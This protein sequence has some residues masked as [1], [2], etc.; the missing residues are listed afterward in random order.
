MY[1]QTEKGNEM[2][3][4]KIMLKDANGNAIAEIIVAGDEAT[5]EKF[6]EMFHPGFKA[7]FNVKLFAGS[8]A[9]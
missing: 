8:P 9:D 1:R 5:A 7:I 6:A 4:Y 2:N 3:T